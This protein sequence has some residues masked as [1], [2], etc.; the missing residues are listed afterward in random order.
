MGLGARKA[1]RESKAERRK[2][3]AVI[4]DLAGD[5][6]DEDEGLKSHLQQIQ[7]DRLRQ[8]NRC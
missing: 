3:A 5:L 7:P 8:R 2:M 1:P 6:I 4:V